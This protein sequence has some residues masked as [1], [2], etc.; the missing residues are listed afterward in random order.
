MQIKTLTN[1][2]KI[3]FFNH[4]MFSSNHASPTKKKN[5]TE[6]TNELGWH[7]EVFHWLLCQFIEKYERLYEI[8]I[9]NN[10]NKIK[11]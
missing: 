5:K 7:L 4:F 11:K 6:K 10:N 9:W 8:M 2:H 3:Q 1:H